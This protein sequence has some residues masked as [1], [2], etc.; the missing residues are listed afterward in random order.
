M[1]FDDFLL[2]T[3]LHIVQVKISFGVL[4]KLMFKKM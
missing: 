2:E 4:V 3:D 1:H